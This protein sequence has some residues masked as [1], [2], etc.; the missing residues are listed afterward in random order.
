MVLF[1]DLSE[2]HDHSSLLRIKSYYSNMVLFLD[3]GEGHDHNALVFGPEKPRKSWQIATMRRRSSQPLRI[4]RPSNN[5]KKGLVIT[6][7]MVFRCRSR[8]ANNHRFYKTATHTSSRA[9]FLCL[10]SAHWSS[11]LT[12]RKARTFF[13]V[14][15]RQMRDHASSL[16]KSLPNIRHRTT[17]C[18]I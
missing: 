7:G 14:A 10:S 2:S 5:P 18:L 16:R 17:P 6:K 15:C 4:A 9:R 1:L 3:L 11:S 12:S 8:D 13:T